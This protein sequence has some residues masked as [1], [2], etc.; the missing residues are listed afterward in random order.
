M[1]LAWGFVCL[2]I[3]LIVNPV[4]AAQ[5]LPMNNWINVK[6]YGAKGDAKTDDSAA[7]YNAIV[8]AGARGITGGNVVYFPS[9]GYLLSS[10]TL[11]PAHNNV[12]LTLYFDGFVN[13]GNHTLVVP[14]GYILHG[15]S[16]GQTQSFSHDQLTMIQVG[17]A[18]PAIHVIGSSRLE[19]LQMIYLQ[20]GADGIVVEAA[21]VTIKNVWVEPNQQTDTTGIPLIVKGGFNIDVEGGGFNAP[22]QGS[23]P[24]VLLTG[25]GRCHFAGP[26]HFT[27][28]FLSNRGILVKAGCDG[29]N[30]LTFEHMLVEEL[31]N[32]FLT[33]DGESSRIGVWAISL[34]DIET[35]DSPVDPQPPLVDAHCSVASG[36]I[37]IWGMQIV[38]CET[39]GPQLTTGDTIYDLEV[40]N[41]NPRGSNKIA[42]SSYYI[43]HTTNGVFNAMPTYQLGGAADFLLDMSPSV[44]HQTVVAG[45]TATWPLTVVAAKDFNAT[46]NLSCLGGQV[47]MSCSVSPPSLQLSSGASV[48]ITANITT[49]AR[50]IGPSLKWKQ[51]NTPWIAT[52]IAICMLLVMI[53]CSKARFGAR[54][55][56]LSGAICMAILL[57]GCAGVVA[58]TPDRAAK[59][60][61]SSGNPSSTGSPLGSYSFYVVATAT[62][63]SNK[64]T[65]QTQIIITIQ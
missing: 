13:L 15:N 10:L 25:D 35:S 9:G 21:G 31:Q 34:R 17:T 27:G 65:H 52:L 7:V 1:K 63:G 42:Q 44:E 45:Q 12:W 62:V 50:S 46:V 20:N 51:P 26:Y 40:W 29:I 5:Q 22:V 30:S 6:D 36:C 64:L 3:C 19:N 43:L 48:P 11:P 38:N 39:G 14:T 2:G 8:A 56:A 24:S 16:S 49:T 37:G 4:C 57:A 55:L 28:T 58:S 60:P 32:A 23:G 47:G 41:A 53:V 61:S 33:I 54:R 18:N 59:S